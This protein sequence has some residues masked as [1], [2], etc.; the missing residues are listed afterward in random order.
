MGIEPWVAALVQVLAM[1]G[2]VDQHRLAQVGFGEQAAEE[3]A[4]A[5]Q[6]AV[7]IGVAI[8]HPILATS[9]EAFTRA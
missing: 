7:F 2:G 3:L 4:N 1:V 9:I 6:H 8:Q 5:P